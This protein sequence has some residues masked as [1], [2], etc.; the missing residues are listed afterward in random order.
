MHGHDDGTVGDFLDYEAETAWD[1][2]VGSNE[3]ERFTEHG[4]KGLPDCTFFGAATAELRNCE[5][6]NIEKPLKRIFVVG[7]CC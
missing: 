5:C 4:V 6:R 7:G 2:S 1:F 3:L